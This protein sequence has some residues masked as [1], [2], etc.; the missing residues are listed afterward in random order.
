MDS[1][2]R[3]ELLLAFSALQQAADISQSIIKS[4][5]KGVVEKDDLSPVTVA[6][7]A[8]QALLLA[9]MQEAY[10]NDTFVG[11]EDASSLR[12]N[13]ALLGRV[14]QLLERCVSQTSK[15]QCKMPSSPESLCACVDEAGR[16]SPAKH[17]RTWVFDPIDG[18][19]TYVRGELY[20]INIGLLVH[21]R[22]VLG[23]VACP[24]LSMDAASGLRNE[25]IDP[26][27]QGC[28]VFAVAGHGAYARPMRHHEP[29]RRLQ[30]PPSDSEIRIVTCLRHSDS[31]LAG[32][33]EAIAATLACPF[34]PACDLLPWVLR[35]AALAL[36]LGNTTFWVYKEPTRRAKVWDHAGAMLLFEEAGGVVTDVCG[37]PIDLTSGR[38]LEANFGFV[39]A[40]KAL[41][42]RVLDAVHHVLRQ[43]GQGA[44]LSQGSR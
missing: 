11:E 17:G 24:N 12:H 34:P 30:H 2:Y 10:P 40:P 18:T 36:A 7:F 23:A 27:G 1:P 5:D 33:H 28:I 4:A 29:L 26:A 32:A 25:D 13:G 43:K 35:W 20:A 19:K 6:D 8:I 15:S 38:K 31:D 21:G 39:A 14:W 9:T 41:H 42:G 22:Q 44:L 3:D 16:S 37:R